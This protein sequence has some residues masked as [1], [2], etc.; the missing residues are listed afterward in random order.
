MRQIDCNEP[1]AG[2]SDLLEKVAP[3]VG[4]TR[5]EKAR[6]DCRKFN[7]ANSVS[8]LGI[9]GLPSAPGYGKGRFGGDTAATEEEH[10][11]KGS[12]AVKAEG[13]S[14]DHSQFVVETLG[15]AVGELCFDIGE[16]SVFVLT[17]S[18][19][20]FYERCQFGAGSPCEPAV[21]FL[22]GGIGGC[23]VEDIGEGFLEQVGA[24]ERSVVFLDRREFAPFLGAEVPWT[25]EQGKAGFLDCTGFFGVV[26]FLQSTDHLPPHLVDSFRSE[27]LDVEAIKDDL[28]LGGLVLD[29]L[30]ESGGHVNGDGFKLSRPL[31]AEFVEE[32]I[33]GF[34][35]FSLCGPDDTLPVVV[36]YDGDVSMSFSVA[37]FVYTDA[38]KFI[39]A[40][41]V[42]F[43]V[44]DALD[45]VADS[46]PGDAEHFGDLGLVGD[47][48]EVGSHLLERFGEAAAWPSPWHHLDLDAAGRAFHS[49]R[50]I[51]EYEPDGSKVEVDP[52]SR[53]PLVVARCDLS[54]LGTSRQPPGRFH[55]GYEAEIFETNAGYEKTG[56][57]YENFG[58]LG[59]AHVVSPDFGVCDEHQN[60]GKTVR[61]SIF[62]S[63]FNE[64]SGG[65]RLR[66]PQ[67]RISY[68]LSM[69]ESQRFPMLGR[70]QYQ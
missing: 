28:C 49:P 25:F 13:S 44:D 63:Y 15:H 19:G 22:F 40:P 42:E 9:C 64:K 10:G 70:L 56:D 30:D 51:F 27:F 35:A 18:S 54:A 67:E 14:S 21:Q 23:F 26:E 59:D 45:D 52:S 34:R 11:N 60:I 6:R 41:W 48:S 1:K 31:F 17:D 16:D 29:G 37:E 12:C 47:L 32:G 61:I 33:E 65:K 53:L 2:K 66:Q 68:P 58:K 4:P 43:V 69:E 5:E 38:L 62:G 3:A 46:G 57:P 50:R 20:G 36:D 55:C 8:V 24:I 39:E 7:E